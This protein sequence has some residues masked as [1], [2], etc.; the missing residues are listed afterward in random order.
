MRTGVSLRALDAIPAPLAVIG[1]VISVQIGAA[2]A[3]DIFPLIGA[4]GSVLL[5]MGIAVVCLW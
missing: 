1:G 5:R 2:L 3:R 4:S